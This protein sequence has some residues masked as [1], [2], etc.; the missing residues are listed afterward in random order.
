MPMNA[1]YTIS[2][3]F[4]IGMG[5]RRRKGAGE[6]GMDMVD[7]ALVTVPQP[8]NT[9]RCAGAGTVPACGGFR[10]RPRARLAGSSWRAEAV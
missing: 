8:Q 2:V 4:L 9:G 7:Q 1:E 5:Y 6:L 3:S 10:A